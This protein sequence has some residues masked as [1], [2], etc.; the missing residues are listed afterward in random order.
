MWRII[1][2]LQP[3]TESWPGLSNGMGLA[4][5]QA[6]F[7]R[8]RQHEGTGGTAAIRGQAG[9]LAAQSRLEVLLHRRCRGAA[10]GAYWQ[11]LYLR[12]VSCS[13]DYPQLVFQAVRGYERRQP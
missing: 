1:C 5:Q 11:L 9:I 4:E 12:V 10:L 6:V 2:S 13:T 7:H 3:F 8:R